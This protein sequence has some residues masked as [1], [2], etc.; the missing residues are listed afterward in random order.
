MLPALTEFFGKGFL[1]GFSMAG[2]TSKYLV[3]ARCK[4]FW[5]S[6]I[7]KISVLD[8]RNKK[9]SDFRLGKKARFEE[10]GVE[11]VLATFPDF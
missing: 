5:S 7:L 4:E 8:P 9:N 10:V 11:R 6:F 2:L 3:N 1:S